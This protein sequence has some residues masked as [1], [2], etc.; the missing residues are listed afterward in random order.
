MGQKAG[1]LQLPHP[2]PLDP[3]IQRLELRHIERDSA[4]KR[5]GIHALQIELAV[6]DAQRRK[7]FGVALIQIGMFVDHRS[8]GGG[9][10]HA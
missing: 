1:D 8:L 4:A 2:T 3:G 6:V 7:T 5:R 9:G 10:V